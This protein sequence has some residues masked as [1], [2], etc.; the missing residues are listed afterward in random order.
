MYFIVTGPVES[1]SPTVIGSN[2]VE[3]TWKKPELLNS[4]IAVI[5]N[6]YLQ[7]YDIGFQ[8]GRAFLIML[9]FDFTEEYILIDCK[10]YFKCIVAVTFI[11]GRNRY[12][13]HLGPGGSMS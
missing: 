6:S 12:Q 10:Q 5:S 3:L 1:L 4:P 13:V 11:G 8:T 2:F 7:G 9:L